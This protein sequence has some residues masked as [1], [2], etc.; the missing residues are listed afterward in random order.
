MSFSAKTSYTPGS[1][2]WISDMSRLVVKTFFMDSIREE[3]LK[4]GFH[5]LLLGMARQTIQ[6]KDAIIQGLLADNAL[7]RELIK[8]TRVKTIIDLETAR[9]DNRVK[10]ML[11]HSEA[12]HKS[13][14]TYDVSHKADRDDILAQSELDYKRAQIES[15]KIRD[16]IDYKTSDVDNQIKLSNASSEAQFKTALIYEIYSKGKRE[17]LLA[18]AE[19]NFRNAQTDEIK[20]STKKVLKIIENFDINELQ[21]ELRAFVV[22]SLYNPSNAVMQNWESMEKFKDLA[23]KKMNEEIRQLEAKT[24]QEAAKARIEHIKADLE[25]LKKKDQWPD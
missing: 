8:Q 7:K 4:Q 12:R 16:A 6:E 13:A 19:R 25:D 3:E 18:I 1:N 15:M 5:D 14:L 2:A 11:A 10:S 22:C 23:L 21:P 17:D 20:A 9:T 24:G